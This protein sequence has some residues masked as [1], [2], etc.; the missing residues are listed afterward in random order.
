MLFRSAPRFDRPIAN[1]GAQLVEDALSSIRFYRRADPE[2]GS[3]RLMHSA[4]I[5][6]IQTLA[7]ALS[8]DAESIASAPFD[9][10][11]ME[12]L[13]VPEAAT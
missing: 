6:E 5:P 9:S 10:L 13:A 8:V 3:I 12:G 4:P 1:N 2:V 7:E 11:V